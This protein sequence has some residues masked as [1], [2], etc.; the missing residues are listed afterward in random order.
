MQAL[1]AFVTHT[2]PNAPETTK[3]TV[4]GIACNRPPYGEDHCQQVHYQTCHHSTN[5]P[6]DHTRHAHDL[7]TTA[8]HC[9]A[10]MKLAA[11]SHIYKTIESTS[12]TLV[13]RCQQRTSTFL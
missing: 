8:T 7:A 10:H 2:H 9:S 12:L 3:S 13:G 5:T 11:K 6:S 1:S 4:P